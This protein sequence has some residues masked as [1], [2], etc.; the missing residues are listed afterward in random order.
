[1][2]WIEHVDTFSYDY[3]VV[4]ECE[5][6]DEAT[7]LQEWYRSRGRPMSEYRVVSR[8]EDLRSEP[9]SEI[10]GLCALQRAKEIMKFSRPLRPEDV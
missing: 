1:M 9:H 8:R 7:S 3:T 5:S 10:L 4:A 6:L 2:Y